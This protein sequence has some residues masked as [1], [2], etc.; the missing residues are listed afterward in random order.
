MKN[1][2]WIVPLAACSA[3]SVLKNTSREVEHEMGA[4]ERQSHL[5]AENK[6]EAQLH[7]GSV[8]LINDS[9]DNSFLMQLWPKG[10]F[11]YSAAGGFKGEAEKVLFSAKTR[12]GTATA[13]QEN[14]SAD[15]KSDQ[16]VTAS[17]SAQHKVE[18]NKKEIQQTVS[19]KMIVA[20]IL[21]LVVAGGLL[22]RY[23]KRK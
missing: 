23:I 8:L 21:I 20:V 2:Y 19:W 12:R 11:T 4:T 10:V 9:A 7:A 3:C 6:T 17:E 5:A 15:T 22:N 14:Y 16:K 1:L 13:K 18:S